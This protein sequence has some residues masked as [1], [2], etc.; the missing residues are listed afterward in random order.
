MRTVPANV[1]AE[2]ALVAR[3]LV[4]QSQL[5]MLAQSLPSSAFYDADMRAIYGAMVKL[6]EDGK[7]IDIVTLR[8]EIGREVSVPILQLTEHHNAPLQEYAAIIKDRAERRGLMRALDRVEAAL[9]DPDAEPLPILSNVF[10]E[11]LAKADTGMLLSSDQAADNYRQILNERFSGGAR[12]LTWGLPGLDEVLLP[13]GQGDQIILAALTSIGKSAA[14]ENV[15]DH[16]AS[17]GHGPV[18]FVS[19][20]MS[21]E[22]LWDRGIAR[23][24]GVAAEKIIRGDLDEYELRLV[25]KAIETRRSM[26]IDYLDA[27]YVTTSDIRAAAA[28]T[29]IRH[30]GQLAGIVV[31]YLQIVS[32]KNDNEVQRVS[33]ISRLLKQIAK[34]Q[35]VPLLAMAQFNRLAAT[36]DP[37]L[38]HL[39]ES[40]SIENNAD[41]VMA[42]V[43][44]R[45][46]SERT[47]K[48][49]KQR[50]GKLASVDMRYDGD[51]VRFLPIDPVARLMAVGEF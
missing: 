17:L 29:R 32:D 47:M 6:T 24:S 37:Q 8:D 9:Q 23:T 43:G 50:Q 15:A 2:E 33:G 20:E 12:G 22:Q 14:A 26:Q 34:E 38:H 39:K 11:Y 40:G 41:V 5:P 44:Q 46:S 28:K 19:L 18:L 10:A 51:R 3:L 4:D 35:R 30:N 13:A 25:Q 16:W 48:I 45:E 1:E 21:Q 36:T 27:G 42:L 7:T 31:D 49:L